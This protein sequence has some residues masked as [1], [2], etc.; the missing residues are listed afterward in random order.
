MPN[1]YGFMFDDDALYFSSFYVNLTERG[2]NLP[3]VFIEKNKDMLG[4]IIM[5]GFRNWFDIKF[6]L[7]ES[8][9]VGHSN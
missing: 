3:A 6:A 2:Y 9:D 8:V 4:D 1:Y 5:T 7:N